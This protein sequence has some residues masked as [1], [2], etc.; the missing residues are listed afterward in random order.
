MKSRPWRNWI[1][2]PVKELFDNVDEEG[3]QKLRKDT[4][5]DIKQ[6]YE[7]Y[8]ATIRQYRAEGILC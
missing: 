7:K 3:F 2:E 8:K 4:P 1:E 5:E 6:E